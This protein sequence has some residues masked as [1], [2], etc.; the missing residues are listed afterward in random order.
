MSD[1]MLPE[2][3][4]IKDIAELAHVSV[5]TVDR[6]LHDRPGVSESS[7][8][9]VEEV[10]NKLDYHPN[11]YASALASNKKY[12]FICLLPLHSQG[13]YWCDV[14]KGINAAVAAFNDFHLSLHFRYYDQYE[15]NS[16]TN[17]SNAILKENPDAVMM[18]PT[19]AS[20]TRIFTDKLQ[21]ALIPFVFV[22]STI[23]E[24][25][26]L[27]FYGQ[28]S[29]Q[30][31]YYAASILMLLSEEKKKVAVIRQLKEGKVGS[32]QQESRE[33]GFRNYMKENYP[34]CKI[35]E[36][37]LRA[38]YPEMDESLLD[39]FFSENPDV[40]CGITFNSKAYIIGE[41]L[42]NR[43]QRNFKLVGYDLL[44][45]NTRCLKKK[46]ISFL[47]AQQPWLQGYY[48]IKSMCDHLILKKE[49]KQINFMPI[50]LL[51]ADN[52]DFYLKAQQ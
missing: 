3:I 2:R 41:Y 1:I 52:V 24:V 47:I 35:L 44:E 20:I 17:E 5:G 27:A 18:A 40:S 37:N 10:L 43:P 29:I 31:G 23:D 8:Q 25:D 4:R 45:R 51:S 33:I 39:H 21:E 36:L 42:E 15:G 30:S 16:F 13:D 32:N 14:E 19:T 7:R 50:D 22:D 6:V 48:G 11:M 12:H 9:R 26:P 28:K 46:Y 34:N 38:K 49:V